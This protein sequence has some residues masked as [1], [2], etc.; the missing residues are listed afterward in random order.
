MIN[1]VKIGII[2]AGGFTREWFLPILQ[3]HPAV[4]IVAICSSSGVSGQKLAEAY[5][6][7]SSYQS[8]EEL[9]QK[10]D[11]DG[12]CIITP[13]VSHHDIAMHAIGQGVHVMCEKPLAMNKSEAKSMVESAI[14]HEIIHGV[15]FTYREN[16][17]VK[18]MKELL[19]ADFI[20]SIY[21]A[22]FEY[23]GAYGQAGPPGWR[24]EKSIGGIGGVLADLGSH[25]ID[26]AQYVLD[27]KI[28]SVNSSVRFLHEEKL[29]DIREMEDVD[30]AADSVFF[31]A[32]FPSG[33]HSSFHTS[34]IHSQGNQNQTI[35][36]KV[37][38]SHGIL[39]LRSSELGIQLRHMHENQP[40]ENIDLIGVKPW[41]GQAE[42]TD[43]RFR[44]WRLTENNEIWKWVDLILQKKA[45]KDINLSEIPNFHDGYSVQKVIDSV[46]ESAKKDLKI[47]ID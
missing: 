37:A 19:E 22:K 7:P 45:N 20:G 41:D 3:K 17:A 1:K 33:F 44:P 26:L 38:G 15:N 23:T 9:L 16:P 6:I 12:I 42:P 24:G 14:K 32:S 21:E 29:K 36:L 31:N 39:E 40:W 46:I 8:H 34:W 4:N 2:G 35:L 30:Q 5:D 47:T 25:L 18:R 10:E 43:E 13:N 28:D 27:E 11:V